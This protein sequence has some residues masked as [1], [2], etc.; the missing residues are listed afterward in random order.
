M[1]FNFTTIIV[2]SFKTSGTASWLKSNNKSFYIIAWFMLLISFMGF[3]LLANNLTR[4][5]QVDFSED[6][7]HTL[8]KDTVYILQNLP[9]PVTAKLYF[10]DILEQRN[11]AMRQMFDRVRGILAQYK[12][13]SNGRF[14]YRIYHPENLDNIEDR[15][16]SDGLQPIPLIDINQNALFGLTLSDT[17]LSTGLFLYLFPIHN[18]PYQF[19]NR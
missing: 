11:P 9:E 2:V 19:L 4:G 18:H 13:V 5:T 1:L 16:I 6:K 15:A 17:F 8:N 12:S 7:L 3:N 10:S 14:D